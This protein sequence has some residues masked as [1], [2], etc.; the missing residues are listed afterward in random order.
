MTT[1]AIEELITNA[2]HTA[3]IKYPE[4]DGGPDLD[5]DWIPREKSAQI[6][7]AILFLDAVD[8]KL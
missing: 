4:G 7:K 2:I 8:F 5:Y 3:F 1:D 6:A